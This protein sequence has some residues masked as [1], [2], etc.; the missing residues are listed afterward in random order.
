MSLSLKSESTFSKSWDNIV[1]FS[2]DIGI[3]EI[4]VTNLTFPDETIEN[5][6]DWVEKGYYADMKWFVES[7]EKRSDPS[8]IIG[9][10]GSAIVALFSYNTAR[11]YTKQYAS[12][13]QDSS[14]AKV[15][16]YAWGK[17]YHDVVGK[18]LKMLSDY[19]KDQFPEINKSLYYVDTGP[20]LE[21]DL[22]IKAKLGWRGK[23]SLLLNKKYGSYFFIGVILVDINLTELLN[24]NEA[25]QID[26][27]GTCTLCIDN[28]PTGAIVQPYVIDSNKCISY[29]TIELPEEKT[30]DLDLNGWVYG[31]DICQEVCPYNNPRNP[32]S[33]IE[34][35][36]E[37]KFGMTVSL[38]DLLSMSDEDWEK[39]KV[40][41]PIK[42]AGM[43]GLK[44]NAKKI[45][46]DLTIKKNEEILDKEK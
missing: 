17:D 13:A 44:K 26:R 39:K 46:S 34:A 38:S 29:L 43:K 24:T 18:K 37:N 30:I 25:K 5:L 6:K 9:E 40:K 23:N 4:G 14:R 41:S 15:A 27:C 21:R 32:L 42:R 22:A 33:P 1:A 7:L 35:F 19:S 3:M 45:I 8:K 12:E 20:L 36:Y 10:N 28:C 31:C 2:K 11:Q 16:K